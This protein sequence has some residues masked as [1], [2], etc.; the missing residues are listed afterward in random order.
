MFRS[1]SPPLLTAVLIGAAALAWSGQTPAQDY[2]YIAGG[3]QDVSADIWNDL[4]RDAETIDQWTSEVGLQR[5]RE[6]DG[7]LRSD[8]RYWP[9]PYRSA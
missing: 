3:A 8:P 1:S 6:Y 4:W 7:E 9:E 5:L 2:Y